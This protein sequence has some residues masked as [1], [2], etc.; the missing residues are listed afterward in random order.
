[1]VPEESTVNLTRREREVLSLIFQGKSSQE[2]ADDLY[3]SKRT[4]DFHLG[5][6]YEKLGVRNRFQAFQRLGVAS[7]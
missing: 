6:A 7:S 4:I 5:Q 3:V 2:V 1:M